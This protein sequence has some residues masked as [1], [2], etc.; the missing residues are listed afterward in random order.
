MDGLKYCYSFGIAEIGI[1]IHISHP[2]K[3]T[4]NFIPFVVPEENTGVH[5]YLHEENNIYLDEK[6][7]LSRK[8]SFAVCK[9]EKGFYRI[10]HDHKENDRPYATG[11]ILSAK[12]EI[13]EYLPDS[14]MFFSE[15]HNVF[16]HIAFE[17]ILLRNEAL[18]LH[19]SFIAT[20][21][22]GLLF[23]G[24][25]GVGKSTQAD[26]W[27]KYRDA[28]QINGD[29]PILK[30]DGNVWKAYGSPYAGS[31]RC[32][33]N[34]SMKVRA[35]VILEQGRTCGIKRM[36]KKEAFC[37]LYEGMIVNTWNHEYVEKTVG[38]VENMADEIPVYHMVCTPDKRAV[39]LLEGMLKGKENGD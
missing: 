25:S 37:K 13:I 20:K 7:A 17:D 19:A 33:V 8:R 14:K 36:N 26:L 2:I 12:E 3:V 10:F 22:G 4:E 5:V 29:R 28:E 11:R 6:K 27:C 39:D 23:S 30:R 31:S 9:D 16:S 24:P 38:M 35:I 15:S 1:S 34:R 21:Y 32:W 18:I